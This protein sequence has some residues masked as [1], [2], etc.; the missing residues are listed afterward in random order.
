MNENKLNII[1]KHLDF[2]YDRV[3]QIIAELI[4]EPSK[5]LYKNLYKAISY[6][7]FYITSVE[8]T[9]LIFQ[10]MLD[11][12][13]KVIENSSDYKNIQKDSFSSIKTLIKFFLENLEFGTVDKKYNQSKWINF[14]PSKKRLPPFLTLK[15]VLDNWDKSLSEEILD[16]ETITEFNGLVLGILD[17]DETLVAKIPQAEFNS[18][19]VLREKFQYHQGYLAEFNGAASAPFISVIYA[20]YYPIIV[21]E[22]MQSRI[23]RSQLLD[24]VSIAPPQTIFEH[25]ENIYT[26][27]NYNLDIGISKNLLVN[28]FCSYIE[29]YSKQIFTQ[30][31]LLNEDRFQ[32]EFARFLFLSGHFPIR[33]AMLGTGR[34]D[35]LSVSTLDAILYELK[36]IGFGSET[37]RNDAKDKLYSAKV[38]IENYKRK[39]ATF[40]NL[41]KDVYIL[42]FSS[43]PITFKNNITTITK[44][45]INFHFSKVIVLTSPVTQ[46]L[47]E[48]EIN[49]EELF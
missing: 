48:E 33:E 10:E 36:Q 37:N 15:D 39:L 6:F 11:Y 8:E 34:L 47:E 14:L 46:N 20:A 38:Q 49:T 17:K 9:R 45:G 12:K 26:Y 24:G 21:N 42:I 1:R 18:L 44:D 41:S 40:P 25:C 43:F 35:I 30:P 13:N 28:R 27:I 4:N 7:I 16:L 3:K 31:E 32:E 19:N 2:R 22:D 29:L 23:V 5:N